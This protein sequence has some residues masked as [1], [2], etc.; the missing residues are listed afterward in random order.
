MLAGPL[1]FSL[2][3]LDAV[4]KDSPSEPGSAVVLVAMRD[5]F[6]ISLGAAL[7]RTVASESPSTEVRFVSYD[8]DRIGDDLAR[9]TV[10]V[11]IAVDPPDS[12][13]LRQAVL[14]QERFVCA[15]P[16][17][18]RLSLRAYLAGGHVVATAHAGY[19]GIDAALAKLGHQRRIVAY[20]S[21]FG[22]ALHL[23]DELGLL[24]TLPSRVA[25]SLPMRNLTVQALPVRVP[26][27][28]CRMIWDA[29]VDADPRSRWLREAVRR[30][31]RAAGKD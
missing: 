15:A 27:F 4:H 6:V 1:A 17:R 29:R 9:G 14:Y 24:A 30:S 3:S 28:A 10:D 13:G 7:L 8:R 19:G 25:T 20:T 22:A 18:K 16:T 2:R 12:P 31:A 21:Y 5:Q 11:A 26:G 23:A